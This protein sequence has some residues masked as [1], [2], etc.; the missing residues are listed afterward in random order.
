MLLFLLE[1]ELLELVVDWRCVAAAAAAA[2]QPTHFECPRAV[3]THTHTH[4]QTQPNQMFNLV[5]SHRF[6]LIATGRVLAVA[7]NKNKN[8]NKRGTARHKAHLCAQ[9]LLHVE[10]THNQT[11]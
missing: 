7:S 4:T 9:L 6:C 1:L 10:Q 5:R 8:K 3:C 2:A 11:F